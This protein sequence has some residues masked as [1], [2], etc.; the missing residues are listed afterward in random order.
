MKGRLGRCY[1]VWGKLSQGGMGEVWLARHAELALPV[2]VKSLPPSEGES[3]ERRYERMLAEARLAARLTSPHV[4]RVIDAGVHDADGERTPY[5]VEEY[6]DGIDLAELD[7]RRRAALRRPLP[8]WAVCEQAAQ[9]ADGLHAAHQAGVVHR[10]VKPS[11]LFGHGHARIKVG[12][13]GVAIC[14]AGAPS[15]GL[16]GG[17]P[18]YMAPE[19]LAGD[20]VDRRADVYSLGATAF[21][22][23]YGE[24]PYGSAADALHPDREPKFPPPRSPEEAYFQHVVSKMLALRPDARQSSLPPVAHQL[25]GLV[26]AT[27]PRVDSV[28]VSEHVVQLGALRLQFEV[29]DLA[30]VETDGVVASTNSHLTMRTGLGDALR[31]AGGDALEAEALGHGEQPLGAC[32]A[33]GAGRLLARGVLH[34][35][36][37]WN[38]VSCVA[39]ATH[40][41]LLLAE[42]LGYQRLA[43]PA[44]GTGAGQVS[45]ESCAE[46]MLG[47]LR[48]HA[49]LGGSRLTELRFVLLDERTL[50]RFCDVALAGLLGEE[51]LRFDDELDAPGTDHAQPT[52]FVPPTRA[53]VTPPTTRRPRQAARKP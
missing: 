5:L 15:D 23:R 48:I 29:G 47:A 6:V 31:R 17:T 33:T 44:I 30:R 45:I 49:Q 9:A 21:A 38:E 1:E 3:F 10:D 8:L 13:F 39:R 24:P 42:E 18:L 19:Q 20:R 52:L 14:A 35:V 2:I 11:N 27:R 7:R 41:A 34:A 28:R 36:G 43:F 51:V 53:T 50:R 4:V 32:V 25:R 26:R 22:L 16:V 37:G 12:D 46:A 40:R